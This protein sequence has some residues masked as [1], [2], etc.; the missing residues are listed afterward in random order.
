MDL[1]DTK[2]LLSN[3]PKFQQHVPFQK[4][5]GEETLEILYG[6]DIKVDN[7]QVTL[8][9]MNDL[10]IA[11]LTYDHVYI[12]GNNIWDVL[13]VFGSVNM[14]KLLRGNILHFIPNNELS[15]VMMRRS[16][17]VW[18]PDFFGYPSGVGDGKSGSAF[19]AVQEEWGKIETTF[20][21][22]GIKGKEAQAFLYLIDE[23]KK[24][25]D[26]KQ[27]GELA[28]KETFNDLKNKPFVTENSILR[29][30]DLG[31]TEFHQLNILRLHELNTVAITAGLLGADA[32]KTDGKISDLM[33]QKCTSAFSEKLKDGVASIQ[34]VLHKKGFPD[35]GE[36]FYNK[37]ID[38]EDILKL[39]NSLQGKI[40][41]YWAMR[42]DYDEEQIQMDIMNSV[43][44]TLGSKLSGVIRFM[45]CSAIGL[46][47]NITGIAASAFDSFILNRVANGWHP[48]FFLD[49]KIK[50]SIDKCIKEKE[51]EEKQELLRQ[52]F[53]GVG[54]NDPCPCGS[55]K[56][57]KYCHG[58]DLRN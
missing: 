51:K 35:L 43:H 33:N 30:N 21:E 40:F 26:Q 55:G 18:R 56:K 39:R 58:R 57:F 47:S 13:S 31:L 16:D 6:Y 17:G 38:L 48:N 11:I 46:V 45:A 4:V 37:V 15:P 10:I 50:A 44:T 12:Q 20:Y 32:I 52:R 2:I 9:I 29:I 3:Y 24:V 41:R 25:L 14:V 34:S 5:G 1:T 19:R 8:Q 54:R 7:H 23:H 53:K 22:K 36:L 27:I 28:R 49:D 42:D